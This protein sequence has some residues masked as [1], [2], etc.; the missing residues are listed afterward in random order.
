MQ[1]FIAS[2]AGS[3]DLRRLSIVNC[4]AGNK[5]YKLLGQ[6]HNL[7]KNLN[8]VLCDGMR[9]APVPQEKRKEEKRH[10]LIQWWKKVAESK[11]I[12]ANYLLIEDL[13]LLGFILF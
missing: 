1:Q 2:L 7:L 5:G 9:P 12:I 4:A 8:E 3:L 6:L 13:A 11:S 10:P